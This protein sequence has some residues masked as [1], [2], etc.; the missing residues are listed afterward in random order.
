MT[1]RYQIE[2][3]TIQEEYDIIDVYFFGDPVLYEDSFDDEFG[4]VE[5]GSYYIL[6][7]VSWDKTEFTDELNKVI[8][9]YVTEHFRDIEAEFVK[10]CKK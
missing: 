9:K 4:K 1:I 6:E 3:T 5:I 7:E 10:K 8:E 2:Y